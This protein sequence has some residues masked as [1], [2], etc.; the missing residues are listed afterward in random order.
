MRATA[1]I[2]FPMQVPPC[3]QLDR[4]GAASQTRAAPVTNEK[5]EN[6]VTRNQKRAP[7]PNG[8][9]PNGNQKPDLG[10]AAPSRGSEMNTPKERRDGPPKW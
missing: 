10:G 2:Y 3:G 8:S 9:G 7:R 1:D 6:Y 4:V 5:G